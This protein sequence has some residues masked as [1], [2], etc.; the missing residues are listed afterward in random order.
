MLVG[1]GTA[2]GAGVTEANS[3]STWNDNGCARAKPN[4]LSDFNDAQSTKV[5]LSVTSIS[6]FVLGG[7]LGGATAAY[8]FT[9]LFTP[10]KASAP[11]ARVVVTPGGVLVQG[12]F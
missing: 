9:D 4:C 10:K 6:T 1:I 2:I 5:A 3:I 11:H 8:A 12:S 7:L